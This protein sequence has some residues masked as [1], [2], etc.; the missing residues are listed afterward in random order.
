MH[1]CI[2]DIRTFREEEKRKELEEE[3]SQIKWDI[4]GLSETMC[5]DEH[6]IK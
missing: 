4:L 2:Y 6:L 1:I 3:M 5:K